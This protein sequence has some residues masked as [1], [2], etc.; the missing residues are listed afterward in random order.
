M[1]AERRSEPSLQFPPDYLPGDSPTMANVYQK[2]SSV[3]DSD[4]PILLVG[5]TG[6]GKECLAQTV[7]LSSRR[8]NGPFLPINCAAIPSDLLEAELFGIA[9]GVATGVGER[10]G[11]LALAEGGTVFLDEIGDMSPALQAKLLRALEEG[12]VQRVG[13]SREAI[14][15]RLIAATN[16]DLDRK[17]EM[18]EFRRD[19]VYR[20]AGLVVVIPPLRQRQEDI[21]AL[22]EHF[23]H[24]VRSDSGRE[25]EGLTYGAVKGLV[26]RRWQG[27]VRELRHAV[28]R[29]L[30]QCPEGRAIDSSMVDGLEDGPITTGDRVGDPLLVDFTS[31]ESLNLEE[32][33]RSLVREAMRRAEGN[34]TAAAALLG[35]TRSSLRRRLIKLFP[36]EL[37]AGAGIRKKPEP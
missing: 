36:G 12:V 19:L 35:I 9:K 3:A 16:T 32:T 2:I 28:R 22:I 15:V 4:L 8:R 17:V 26:G 18:G 33:N 5:E 30:L 27:N 29:L 31:W 20:L 23:F 1:I 14:D 34:Q 37:S 10:P 25:V 7:H 21:G 24:R 6:V 11:R 13:G